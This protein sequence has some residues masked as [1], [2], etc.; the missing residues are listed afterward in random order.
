MSQDQKLFSRGAEWRIWD[1]HVHTPASFEWSG[2]KRFSKMTDD[3]KRTSVDL[4]IN[5]I[6]QADPDVFV[7]MDYWTFD[8][9]FALK[10]RITEVGSPKLE[11]TVFPGIDI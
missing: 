1:L 6:N 3:E 10:K 2:G 9:W 4:M 11:K 5:T 7:L 8:G